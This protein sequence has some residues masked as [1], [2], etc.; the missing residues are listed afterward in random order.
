MD[1][2]NGNEDGVGDGDG[3]GMGMEM[4]IDNGD[5]QWEGEQEWEGNRNELLTMFLYY[6]S[7]CYFRNLICTR[8]LLK[9]VA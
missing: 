6:L 8:I 2:N 3:M 1:G 9:K 7:P 5:G 4:G